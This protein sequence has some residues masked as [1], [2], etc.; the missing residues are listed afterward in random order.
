[1]PDPQNV[2]LQDIHTEGPYS[3]LTELISS[4]ERPATTTLRPVA[5]K[6]DTRAVLKEATHLWNEFI[7]KVSARDEHNS[8]MNYI[9]HKCFTMSYFTKSKKLSC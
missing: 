7:D 5:V 1:M 6:K 4:A 3:V 8:L 2:R 9:D